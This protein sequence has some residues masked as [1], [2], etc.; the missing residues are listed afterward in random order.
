[1][2]VTP[3]ATTSSLSPPPPPL[4]ND[5]ARLRADNTL[6]YVRGANGDF[7]L[8]MWLRNATRMCDEHGRTVANNCWFTTR[9]P[10]G[11]GELPP[12]VVRIDRVTHSWLVGRAPAYTFTPVPELA[13]VLADAPNGGATAAPPYRLSAVQFAARVDRSLVPPPGAFPVINTSFE[14]FLSSAVDT[15]LP[16]NAT[17]RVLHR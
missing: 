1:M 10:A 4:G 6:S 15:G 2:D 17:P 12:C 3:A 16:C 5:G 13:P 11:A 9:V 14:R 7:F 8:S